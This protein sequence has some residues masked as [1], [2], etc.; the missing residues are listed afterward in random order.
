MPWGN[1]MCGR[2]DL[3][4]LERALVKIIDLDYDYGLF[5]GLYKP[6]TGDTGHIG[7]TGL[8]IQ[9][10]SA[11]SCM[12]YCYTFSPLQSTGSLYRIRS[13]SNSTPMGT[14]RAFH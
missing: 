6:C 2:A 7:C 13:L 4:I 14:V 10:A 11:V 5:S 8:N 9:Q 12:D 3:R 1:W